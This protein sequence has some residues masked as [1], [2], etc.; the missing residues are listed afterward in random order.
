MTRG[1]IAII[2]DSAVYTSIEFNGNMYVREGLGE[3]IIQNLNKVNSYDDYEKYVSEFNTEYFN[4]SEYP[5]I[6]EKEKCSLNFSKNYIDEWG[7]EY[8]YIKNLT[9]GLVTIFD[10]EGNAVKI[11]PNEVAIFC[12]GEY[13]F[14]IDSLK[15]I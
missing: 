1:Q 4:Y 5:L 12:L 11:F 8:L 2:T 15:N 7:S 6:C 10:R 14:Y 13:E 9:V 3:K